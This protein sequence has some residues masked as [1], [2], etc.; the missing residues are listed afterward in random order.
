MSILE[1]ASFGVPSLGTA[2]YGIVDAIEDQKTGLLFPLRDMQAFYQNMEKLVKS[3]ELQEKL[4]KQA[5]LR[6]ETEFS[7][8][9]FYESLSEILEGLISDRL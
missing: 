9:K 2:I 1:A 8:E 4:G 6:V 7:E 5:R 3:K